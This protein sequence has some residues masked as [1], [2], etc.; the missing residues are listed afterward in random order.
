MKTIKISLL[1]FDYH[2]EV[3]RNTLMIF[4]GLDLDIQVFAS[5]EIWDKA[6]MNITV[7]QNHSQIYLYDSKE[8]D[9]YSFLYSN[10]NRLN[11]SDIILFN[12]LA[13]NFRSF[14][15]LKL[16]SNLILRIH[17]SNAYFNAFYNTYRPIYSPYFIWKDLSHFLRNSIFKLDWLYRRRFLKKVDYFA[18]P[19]ENIR[20]Y[21]VQKLE[22]P[23][24]QSIALPFSFLNPS[25]P[26]EGKDEKKEIVISIIGKLDKR[27][28][29]YDSVV[30][31]FHHISER[32]NAINYTIKLVLLGSAKTRYGS[33]IL[34]RLNKISCPQII[35]KSFKG[36]VKQEVFDRHMKE[37]D[38][39]IL[40]IR[41][42][43]RYTVYKEF[44]GSTKISGGINDIMVYKKPALIVFDYPLDKEFQQVTSTYKNDIDLA[45]KIMK[46]CES[47]SYSEINIDKDLAKSDLA[48]IRQK[49]NE[50]FK[51]IIKDH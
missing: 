18:F 31:A 25:K 46:W 35:I 17:N 51:Q 15:R 24:I 1:E 47:K 3:L 10:I 7:L 16:Q 9:L 41:I 39:L 11:I 27:N 2:P 4:D 43:T 20:N 34:N 12:T 49:Y 22:V 36:F 13:S 37:T 33:V 32:M 45:E 26:I 23:A 5:K 21:A 50:I 29:D 40:P 14:E 30:K 8:S 6:N 48:N 38:F 19:S 28:R 44:Y 42:N